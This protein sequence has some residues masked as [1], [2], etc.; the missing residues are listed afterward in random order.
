MHVYVCVYIY[1]TYTY[2]YMKLLCLVTP[3]EMFNQQ[4]LD[5]ETWCECP[6]QGLACI[7]HLQPIFCDNLLFVLFQNW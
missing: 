7:K 6:N 3:I 1:I 5:V 4:N 2:I